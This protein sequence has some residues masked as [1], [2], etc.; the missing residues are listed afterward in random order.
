MYQIIFYVG[1]SGA[2]IFFL[3]SVLL[4]IKNDV[5]KLIGDVS[6]WNAKRAIKRLN[7]EGVEDISKKDAIRPATSKILVRSEGGS[8]STDEKT[9]IL[10][11][12]T[13][14]LYEEVT[15]VLNPVDDALVLNQADET[16]ILRPEEETDVLRSEEET[17]VLRQSGETDVLSRDGETD[18]LIRDEA[19]DILYGEVNI[20]FDEKDSILNATLDV[21]QM[22][23][24]KPMP[25]IFE[26][27]EDITVVHSDITI[28]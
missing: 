11:Q 5:A 6:G 13:D 17:D 3:L 7:Q 15:D 4:F 24:E 20:S 10:D 12:S 23:K 14:V 22:E 2:I 16:D 26:V 28:R 19:T 21:G 25:D 27:E 8:V 1:L 18:V 9:D